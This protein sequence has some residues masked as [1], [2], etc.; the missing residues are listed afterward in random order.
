M[1]EHIEFLLHLPMGIKFV[2]LCFKLLTAGLFIKY[3]F[4]LKSKSL[5][6]I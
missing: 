6:S 2:S 1:T 3:N 4:A 5:V